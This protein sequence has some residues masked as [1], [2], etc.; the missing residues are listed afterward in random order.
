MLPLVYAKSFAPIVDGT[1]VG[2]K[3]VDVGGSD[4]LDVDILIP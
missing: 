3:L 2:L 4:E 1:I